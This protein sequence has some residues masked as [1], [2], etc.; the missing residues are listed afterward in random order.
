MKVSSHDSR[1]LRSVAA[2]S[3]AVVVF[4]LTVGPVHAGPIPANLGAGLYGLVADRYVAT[5]PASGL[6]LQQQQAITSE[7]MTVGTDG[8]IRDDT[9]RVLVNIVVD[10]SYA[11]IDPRIHYS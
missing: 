5:H 7:M 2:L 4:A 3:W 1:R 10:I 11:F 8:L 9:N 6:A